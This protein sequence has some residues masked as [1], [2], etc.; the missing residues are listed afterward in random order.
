MPPF[1]IEIN[2]LILREMNIDDLINH[3]A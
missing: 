1:N 2:Q 3:A